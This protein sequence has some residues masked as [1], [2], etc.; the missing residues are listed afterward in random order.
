[1]GG[2]ESEEDSMRVAGA[3]RPAA[4][5]GAAVIAGLVL[6]AAGGARTTAAPQNTADPTIP[7]ASLVGQTLTATRGTWTG[8]QPITYAYAWQRCDSAGKNCTP[9]G[10]ATSSSYLATSADLGK[11]LRVK[12]TASNSS[13]DVTATSDPTAAIAN[14]SG[15]PASNT[16]PAITGD[17]TVGST[18]TTSNGT[19]TGDEPITY[20]YQ[21]QQC[22]Q[23]GNAC[24]NE[25]NGTKSTYQVSKDDS[26]H[27]IRSQVSAKNSR[28]TGQAI[29]TATAVVKGSSSS[30]GIIDIGGG[31][32]SA[33]VESLVPGDRLIVKQVT[34]TPNPITST[35]QT[36]KAKVTVT[37]NK[38][39]YVRGAWVFIRTTPVLTDT[40][41]DP[42]T[43]TDGTTTFTIQPRPDFPI[44]NGY[45]VQFFVKAYQKGDDPLAARL[46]L[47]PRPDRDQEAMSK[48]VRVR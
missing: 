12:V 21:W 20:S 9:I 19:W 37:D 15:K 31:R 40:V 39:N 24:S 48:E 25:A 1:M 32:K 34:F 18:L 10:G 36:I 28:G 2:N 7:G 33:P 8:T 30:G 29:S 45:S 35:N 44:K 14:P 41:A 4:T 26:G 6:A 13:G 16:A 38:G 17:A 5:T 42:Q 47:S 3:V 46:G 11:Q 22:D 27:T 43:S 23:S